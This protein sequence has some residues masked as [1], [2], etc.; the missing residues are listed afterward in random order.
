MRTKFRALAVLAVLAAAPS[1]AADGVAFVTDLKGE[2]TVDGAP[3]PMLMSELAKGQKV[4]VGR[5]SRLALMFVQSGKEFVLSGP[6]DYLVGDRDVAVRSGAAPAGRETAWRPS[7]EVLVKVA[8]TSS[9]SIRMRS[10]APAKPAPKPA[11]E[12]PTRGAVAQLQPTLR[13]TA[14]EAAGPA[15]VTLFVAG[16]EDRPLAKAKVTGTSHRFP[17][18]LRPDTEYGWSV[19]VAGDAL[20]AAT[21]R[22]LPAAAI[23]GAEK[24]RPAEKAE[25][26]DRLN[27]ALYLQD[28]GALQEAQEA[29]GRLA[30][31]RPDLPELASLASAR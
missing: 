31:E 23:Q 18:K 15:E 30:K 6:G 26:T 11:L 19:T 17:A 25:F 20:G 27:Y 5:D 3:R 4:V 21:F 22:T 7:G 16:K 10:F 28:L 14:P 9:A 24:R 13:W 8:Q 1:Q 2:V 12:F 29:F